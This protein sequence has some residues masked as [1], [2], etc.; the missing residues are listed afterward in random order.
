M[1]VDV[2]VTIPGKLICEHCHKPFSKETALI[3][4]KCKQMERYEKIRTPEGQVALLAYQTWLKVQRRSVPD[5]STFANSATFTHFIK[6]GA[7]CIKARVNV[8]Q[9]VRFMVNRGF[10]PSMWIRDD[11]ITAFLSENDK[12][13]F[14]DELLDC[15]NVLFDLADAFD[16]DVSELY[17][18]LTIDEIILMLKSG[19][20]SPWI[21][22]ISSGFKQKIKAEATEEQMEEFNESFDVN[23]WQQRLN[24]KELVQQVR[25]YLSH[26]G[27]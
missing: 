5:L 27:L 22:F 17:A 18:V 20:L 9:Y 6:F 23:V 15:V 3:N 4:H 21:V 7:W 11:V 1:T 26:M 25:R 24:N 13:H 10:N 16:V 2:K 14:Q 12:Q 8:E 19:R